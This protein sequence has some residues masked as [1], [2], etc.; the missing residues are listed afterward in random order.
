MTDRSGTERPRLIVE[1]DGGSRGNPGPAGYGALV[2]DAT[3]GQILHEVA[4]GIGRATNN[5]AEYSGLIAGL[6][7]AVALAPGSIEVRM[8]SKLVIEQMAGR[9]QVKHPAMKPLAEQA[10]VAVR[11]LGVP[12]RWTWV[13]RERNRD[14]DRLA[15][16]AMDAAARGE[17]WRAEG[18]AAP[19]DLQAAPAVDGTLFDAEPLQLVP[20][21]APEAAPSR[22]SGWM[23]PTADPTTT[24]LLRHGQ[25]PLSA[26]KRFSGRGDARLTELGRRQAA[27]TAVAL[28]GTHS[29]TVAAVVASPLTRAQETAAVVAQA[30]GVPV[31]TDD[32]LVET[33]F[34]AFEGLTFAEA[35]ERFPDALAAW[36]ADDT[37]APPG[38]ES[39]ADTAVRVSRAR[40]R[41]REAYPG[42]T[43]LVVSH[44]TPIKQLVR[45]ALAAP[46]SALYALHLDLCSLSLVDW[47]PDGPAVVRGFNDV[48]HL[49][50]L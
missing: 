12:V 10:R 24:V 18:M 44:V 21:E 17:L 36:L 7:A 6:R 41:L 15:N 30:L 40:D 19:A 1:A 46:P 34:G 49:G 11:A 38:G 37:I 32:D 27:V 45:L 20:A 31:T 25:T 16:E 22:R 2:R 33:D 47:Y 42:G 26:E 48:G 43:V 13:P 28:A 14:A 39:F 29:G 3:S 50:G 9:W 4:A 35:H 23:A 5:V 8:D